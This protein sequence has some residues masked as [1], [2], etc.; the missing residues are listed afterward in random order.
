VPADHTIVHT[1]W[2]AGRLVEDGGGTRVE[3]DLTHGSYD[4]LLAVRAA[5][6]PA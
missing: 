4:H 1:R 6:E 3:W 5:R 2:Y